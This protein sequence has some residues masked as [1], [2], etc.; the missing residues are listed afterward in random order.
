MRKSM[1]K[2]AK[3]SEEREVLEFDLGV[4]VYPPSRD[5]GYWRIRWDER[6]QGKD[7]TAKNQAAA[8][9]KAQDIVERLRRSVP[10][11][12]G[13]AKGAHLVAHYLDPRR[14]PPRVNQWSVKHREE[15]T[16][17]CQ[18]YILPVIAD[19]SCRDLTRA[20]FQEIIDQAATASVAH[21]IAAP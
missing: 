1:S 3:G 19:I 14:R 12:L 10:T 21:H 11:E 16:R 6:R 18:K 4:R 15:Q 8:I 9:R 17:I 20:D 13:R 5:G 2:T 7:T